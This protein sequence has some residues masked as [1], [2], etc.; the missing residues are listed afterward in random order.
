MKIYRPEK[1]T[2][3]RKIQ[4]HPFFCPLKAGDKQPCLQVPRGAA[5]RSSARRG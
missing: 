3:Q 2:K 1:S 5:A 4:P